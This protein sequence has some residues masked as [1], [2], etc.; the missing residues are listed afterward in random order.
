MNSQLIKKIAIEIL[1]S[2]IM[3]VSE[4]LNHPFSKKAMSMGELLNRTNHKSVKYVQGCEATIKRN[5]PSKGRWMFTVKCNERWSKGP[6]N[7]RFKLVSERG[8]KTKGI[9]GREIMISCPCRAWKY[10]GADYNSL[11]KD[12]NERQFS[13]GA[14]PEIRDPRRK[15]LICKHVAAC[16]PLFKD[17]AIPKGF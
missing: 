17:F 6:Y 5:M 2:R 3:L 15:Y 9:L 8:K 13:N 11:R 7:V 14:P 1:T 12:Y 10:N 16:V 4:L